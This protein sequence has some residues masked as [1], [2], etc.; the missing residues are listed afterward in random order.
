[1]IFLPTYER[2]SESNYMPIVYVTINKINGRKYLGK[3]VHGKPFY[4]GSGIAITNA[5]EK[6]GKSSFSRETLCVVQTK[7]EASRI[8]K[9]LSLAWDVANGPLW[10]NLKAGGEGGS[11]K[12]RRKTEEEKRN[13]SLSK[14]G[15]PSWNKGLKGKNDPRCKLSEEWKINHSRKVTGKKRSEETK[16]L[17]ALKATGR[18]H[19][20]ETKLKMSVSAKTRR[21]KSNG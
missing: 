18:T 8:E 1:M 19:T 20:E 11:V 14:Q 16:A 10:Y 12:G 17:M 2:I 13:I 4:L 3:S 21:R 7:E 5:I 9:H 6:Y 15:K